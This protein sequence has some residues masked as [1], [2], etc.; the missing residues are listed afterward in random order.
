MSQ[1]IDQWALLIAAA[2]VAAIHMSAPDHWVTLCTLGQSLKWPY[3]KLFNVSI[4]TALGH[5]LFSAGL[6]FGVLVIGLATSTL[7]SK[8]LSLVIGAVMVAAGLFIAIR[9]LT[10]KKRL[11][12]TPEEKLLRRQTDAAKG[13]GY[14]ALLGAAL[15]PDLTIAPVFL[16]G[17]PAGL[18]F[19]VYL[20]IVF[21]VASI[22]CQATYVQLAAR[23][24]TK[25]FERVP[26]KYTDAVVGF[27]IAG[28][29]VFVAVTA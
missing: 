12:V 13:L 2:T 5:S 6:G 3:R 26:E 4:I 14:F 8:Y 21:V 24:F 9:A 17:V 16:A 15:S 18:L 28:I 25:G 27:V 11:E 19:G 1:L 20:F 29:G 23:G 22:C 7:I 10:S